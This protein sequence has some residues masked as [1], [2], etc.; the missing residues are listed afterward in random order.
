MFLS[1]VRALLFGRAFWC[2]A[3]LRRFIVKEPD[4]RVLGHDKASRKVCDYTLDADDIAPIKRQDVMVL[5]HI[6]ACLAPCD[7]IARA[8]VQPLTTA[9]SAVDSFNNGWYALRDL[10]GLIFVDVEEA[11][12]GPPS[13]RF[14][15][16][17]R[18]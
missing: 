6:A 14:F 17:A 1:R 18:E 11:V 4:R 7:F 5:V 10:A 13:L 15:H 2:K 12:D 16:H 9:H 8:H 3:S